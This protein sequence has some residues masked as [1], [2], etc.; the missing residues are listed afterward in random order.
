MYLCLYPSLVSKWDGVVELHAILNRHGS[1][2]FVVRVLKLYIFR[3]TAQHIVPRTHTVSVT[4]AI[5]QQQW[6]ELIQPIVDR[7]Q[8][9]HGRSG[10]FVTEGGSCSNQRGAQLQDN[11]TPSGG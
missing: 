2:M 11:N 9:A 4:S 8:S 10:Q 5:S 1:I 6:A 7:N 3:T